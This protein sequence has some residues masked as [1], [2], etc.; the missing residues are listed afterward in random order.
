MKFCCF[1]GTTV[2]TLWKVKNK[3]LLFC[4][5]ISNCAGAQS[6]APKMAQEATV[7]LTI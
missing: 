2:S 4:W 6:N 1:A 5:C 7:Q 3:I